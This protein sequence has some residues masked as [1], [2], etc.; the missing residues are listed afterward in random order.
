[1]STVYQD[2]TNAARE[3]FQKK[4]VA[5]QTVNLARTVG[6]RKIKAKRGAT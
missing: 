4:K 5:T 1:V 3:N 2:V 6:C